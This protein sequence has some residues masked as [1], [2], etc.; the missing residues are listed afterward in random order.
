M[1]KK[2]KRKK[3]K[4]ARTLLKGIKLLRCCGWDHELLCLAAPGTP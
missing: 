2:K 1:F 3:R 4:I